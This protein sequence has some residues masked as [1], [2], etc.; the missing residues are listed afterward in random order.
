M[1]HWSRD[2]S[3]IAYGYFGSG[4]PA[5]TLAIQGLQDS[6][7]AARI[8]GEAGMALFPLSWT[9]EGDGLL[10]GQQGM[11][12]QA[13]PDL[14]ILRLGT[15]TTLVPYLHAD[16]GERSGTISPDGRWVAYGS[17]ETGEVRLYVR[18]FPEPGPRLDV[19]G[20]SLDPP[21]W[22][23]DG[24]TL[25]WQQGDSMMAVDIRT[26]PD[27]QVV[28]PPRLLFRG[29]YLSGFDLDPDGRFFMLMSTAGDSAAAEGQPG[30][31]D[32][33]RRTVLVVN[34]IE[35]LKERVGAQGGI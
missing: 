8:E 30:D 4:A 25:Y 29:P 15:D 21:R 34:W 14:L 13:N 1:P 26:D 28:G 31:G 3:R 32:G 27:L 11:M 24:G 22:S 5:V 23:V 10:V 9:P 35:E 20:Y 7:P 16:W 12:G 17:D 2:G 18:S 33:G 19:P 6:V